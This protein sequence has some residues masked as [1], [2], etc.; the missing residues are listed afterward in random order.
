MIFEMANSLEIHIIYCMAFVEMT[1]LR[2]RLKATYLSASK[3]MD[4]S[5]PTMVPSCRPVIGFTSTEASIGRAE[6]SGVLALFSCLDKLIADRFSEFSHFIKSQF[7]R[8]ISV[9]NVSITKLFELW[10]ICEGVFNS[11]NWRERRCKFLSDWQQVC[12]VFNKYLRKHYCGGKKI[13]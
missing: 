5:E 8:P 6:N 12:C 4:E 9:Q 7:Y 13:S 10:I 2:L 11:S 1:I 3:S